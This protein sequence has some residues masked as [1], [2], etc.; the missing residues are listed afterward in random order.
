MLQSPTNLPVTLVS[1]FVSNANQRASHKNGE[2]LRNGKLFLQSTTPKIVF[3]DDAMFSQ[4]QESDYDP[5]TTKLVLY[6]KENMYFMNYLDQLTNYTPPENHE[7]NTKEFLLVMWNK[8]EY[9]REAILLNPFH[10]EHFVWVDFGIRYVCTHTTDEQFVHILNHFS[11]PANCNHET[12]RIGGIWEPSRFFFTMN[13]LT[14]VLWYF[15]GGV[16][17]GHATALKY[18]WAEMRHVCDALVFEH[19]TGTWEVNL[20]YFIYQKFPRLFDIYPCDHNESLLTGYASLTPVAEFVVLDL[21]YKSVAIQPSPFS[22][23][24]LGNPHPA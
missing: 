13:P 17:G 22:S 20:W 18:F 10:T 6:G 9:M 19:S 15:A 5:A 8:T 14:Q 11:H 7:K 4:I 23:L 3:L 2:Y 24:S 1:A 12:V 21:P 16:F